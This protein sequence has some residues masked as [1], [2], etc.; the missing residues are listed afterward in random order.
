MSRQLPKRILMTADTIGGVWT[1]ALEWARGL[2]RQGVEVGLATMGRELTRCQREELNNLRHVRLYES[3]FK[4]EWMPDPWSDVLKAGDWLLELE[5]TFHPDL[6]HLNGFC[7]G[8]LPWHAPKIV[9]GHSCVLSWWRAVHKTDTPPEW[10]RYRESVYAGLQAAD[11]IL[12]PSQSML[13]M[14]AEHYGPFRATKVIP[15]GRRLEI[16]ANISKEPFILTAGRVWDAAKNIRALAEIAPALP[17]PVYIAGEG[18][19]GE[20]SDSLAGPVRHLGKLSSAELA[21]WFARAAIYALPAK[22]E[23]FGLSAL[24]AAQAGCALVLGDL[25]S[26]REIWGS[27]ALYVPSA[28]ACALRDALNRLCTD[29]ELRAELGAR[30]RRKAAEYT[31]ERMLQAYLA[32]CSEASG[33]RWNPLENETDNPAQKIL[34]L[35]PAARKSVENSAELAA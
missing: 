14:L 31:P 29:P 5:K 21:P 17:W 9:M 3:N 19:L 27:A 22:Y 34:H 32:A 20:A 25:Q 35:G 15:N 24:E 33:E 13:G 26:L 1:Y 7:H 6:V 11:L 23:P 28:E 2:D 30:A 8:A 10:Q 12:A 18:Q 16:T 4:L